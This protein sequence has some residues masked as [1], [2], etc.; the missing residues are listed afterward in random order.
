MVQQ[1]ISAWTLYEHSSIPMKK[2][3]EF[4]DKTVLTVQLRMVRGWNKTNDY[5]GH[6]DATSKPS[7]P[8]IPSAKPCND[9]SGIP[10]TLEW[11]E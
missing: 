11:L 7:K 8:T 1:R 3:I 2:M 9:H 6:S 4:N 10:T 5:S